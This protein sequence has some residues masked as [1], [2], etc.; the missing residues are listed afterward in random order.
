MVRHTHR[1][2]PRRVRR[3][4]RRLHQA[5]GGKL[6][7]LPVGPGSRNAHGRP[8]DGF[9][10]SRQLEPGREEVSGILSRMP[11][12]Y[13]DLDL[14]NADDAQKTEITRIMGILGNA[15]QK[16][17][18][19]QS[20]YEEIFSTLKSKGG[21]D[22]ELPDAVRTAALEAVKAD[23]R[24][25]WDFV[26]LDAHGMLTPDLPPVIIP[27]R[28][29]VRFNSP[30]GCISTISKKWHVPYTDLFIGA[31]RDVFIDKMAEHYVENTG[32]LQSFSSY[33]ERQHC[34]E[35]PYPANFC[36]SGN[37]LSESPWSLNK[38]HP[39]K[40][41]T[42]ITY[43]GPGDAVGEMNLLFKTD[44]DALPIVLLGA[45]TLPIRPDVISHLSLFTGKKVSNKATLRESIDRQLFGENTVTVRG[46]SFPHPIPNLL[47][48]VTGRII[49]LSEALHMLGPV[50][51]GK[52]RLLYINS[53][54][55]VPPVSTS[56][57]IMTPA[58]RRSVAVHE[59]RGSIKTLEEARNRAIL[60]NHA[61]HDTVTDTELFKSLAALV[62]REEGT[63]VQPVG[64]AGA[65]MPAL[66]APLL[67]SHIPSISYSKH[68]P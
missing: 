3:T 33:A 18:L 26:L 59:R 9:S 14:Y 25:N 10:N 39:D 48:S 44:F 35:G 27:E 37:I 65:A 1:R 52:V 40:K 45:Y 68:T 34:F 36:S 56:L 8:S 31:D 16:G 66:V 55:G 28:T 49:H 17:I 60:E 43:Y 11:G 63:N 54:R 64:D 51:E 23:F 5:G 53:C 20:R 46:K 61:L 24:A 15:V 67:T 21:L 19:S 62:T 13:N 41:Y 12:L 7:R 57:G 30:A 2:Y 38:K 42:K 4:T 6:N 32:P 50:P 29:Y 58:Q 22:D 47:R